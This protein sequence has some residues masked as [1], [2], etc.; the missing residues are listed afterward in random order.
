VVPGADDDAPANVAA[1]LGLLLPADTAT[2]HV[3]WRDLPA[4]ACYATE[5]QAR[6]L[7]DALLAQALAPSR[8]PPTTTTTTTTTTTIVNAAALLSLAAFYEVGHAR[9]VAQSLCHSPWDLRSLFGLG[10]CSKTALCAGAGR[11][12]PRA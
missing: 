2:A 11:M 9:C 8:S 4:L 12:P 7:L 3:L 5:A 6:A 1:M 10:C